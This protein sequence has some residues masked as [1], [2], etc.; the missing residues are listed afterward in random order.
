LDA[1]IAT[2]RNPAGGDAGSANAP[3]AVL[4]PPLPHEPDEARDS[5]DLDDPP[6]SQSTRMTLSTITRILQL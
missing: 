2:G 4:K 3:R 5:H 6:L 1:R